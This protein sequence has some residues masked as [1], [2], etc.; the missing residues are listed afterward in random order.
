M[1]VAA[2]A[3]RRFCNVAVIG[4]GAAGL[5]AARELRLEGHKVVVFESGN[6]VGGTWV[7]S[8]DTDSDPLGLD[9]GRKRVQT[10]LYQSLRTN[11]PREA[12]GFRDYPFVA[13]PN[14]EERDSRRFPGHRE[15]LLYLEDF[16]RDFGLMGLVR[17]GT[18]AFDVGMV[19]EGR[20][21]VRSRKVRM[22]GCDDASVDEEEV[23]D[24]V[25]VCNGHY[26][27][28]RIAD[29]PGFSCS[30]RGVGG[31]PKFMF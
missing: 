18:E 14:N 13:R 1:A 27:Q 9:P 30:F 15:V 16:A 2:T 8:P 7:Y 29:I 23:Y 19:E 28:P 10:S 22:D 21:M 31:H 26:T 5:V 4:A 12:M 17:F 20:W 25:V 24:G 6:S 11:L 3:P